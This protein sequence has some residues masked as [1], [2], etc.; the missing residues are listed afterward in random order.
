M[1]EKTGIVSLGF[2]FAI[3][4]IFGVAGPENGQKDSGKTA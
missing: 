4:K 1:Q 2:G 3:D